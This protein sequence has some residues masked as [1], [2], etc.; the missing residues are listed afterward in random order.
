MLRQREFCSTHPMCEWT[1][2]THMCFAAQTLI[3]VC[4]LLCIIDKV[5]LR[6]NIEIN[7]C[8]ACIYIP[9]NRAIYVCA[10]RHQEI[11]YWY[12]I[13]CV[14]EC[15]FCRPRLKLGTWH[16]IFFIFEYF[17]SSDNFIRYVPDKKE[18]SMLQA[19]KW[20]NFTN[21]WEHTTMQLTIYIDTG[22]GVISV[23]RVGLINCIWVRS[24]NLWSRVLEC[25]YYV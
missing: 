25:L 23:R 8:R 17:F 6:V 20:C 24:L 21:I 2:S 4:G 13:M 12:T 19:V 5:L 16:L 9:K 3:A 15:P 1:S 22:N 10:S 7:I 11:V 18:M 14:V